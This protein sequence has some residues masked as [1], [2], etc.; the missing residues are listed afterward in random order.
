M[1]RNGIQR[2]E[3]VARRAERKKRKHRVA[4]GAAAL[5]TVAAVGA[6]Q[7][8]EPAA[9][10]AAIVPLPEPIEKL[11]T[12]SKSFNSGNPLG[13]L[14]SGI[15][16]GALADIAGEWRIQSCVSGASA[17]NGGAD[18]TQSSTEFG[19]LGI[20]VVLPDKIEVVPVAIYDPVKKTY[21]TLSSSILGDIARW[22]GLDVPKT[23]TEGPRTRGSATV[24]GN[25]FQLAVASRD[26][27]ATA[28]S[29]LPIS[30]ATAGATDGRTAKSFALIGI[31]HAWNAD[32][33]KISVLGQD[34]PLV[35][36][37]GIKGVGCYGGITAAYA[38]GVG[39]C[40]NV[41]ATFDFRYQA[42][43]GE[44]QF[45]L[46]DPTALLTDP[47]GVLGGAGQ[48]VLEGLLKGILS[49]EGIDFD[50]DWMSLSKDFSR[51]SLAGDHGLFS[52]NFVRLTSEYG[53]TKPIEIEWMGQKVTLYPMVEVNGKE[54]PNYLGVPVISF[55]QLDTGQIVPVI[56]IPDYELP[57]LLPTLDGT[58]LGGTPTNASATSGA[59]PV[60]AR[61]AFVA[62]DVTEAP[63]APLA[64]DAPQEWAPAAGD[65]SLSAADTSDGGEEYVGK[66]REQ[67]HGKHRLEDRSGD[68]SSDG[69]AGSDSGSTSDSG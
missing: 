25:G 12:W 28:I 46:T 50:G 38:D 18:C 14:I 54:R 10:E 40:A 62:D 19:G 45:A 48:E 60:A 67:Y 31:A 64:T 47:L 8:M 42:T 26:G 51:L 58:T 65:A 15:G 3:K 21:D 34:L 24:I 57:F 2:S 33:T 16:N 55:G 13:G 44:V 68:T 20:A 23:M 11:E 69:G 35:Q 29:F 17:P 52:G 6:G 63:P 59:T 27:D 66:H 36:V 53:F 39:A 30:I 1:G 37:P 61:S 41:G 7:A 22:I 49:K 56:H 9:A 5:A 32:P 4:A 43:N